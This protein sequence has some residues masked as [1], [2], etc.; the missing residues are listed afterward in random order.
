MSLQEGAEY[1]ERLMSIFRGDCPPNR[2]VTVE[3]MTHD[4]W[5]SMRT[6]DQEMAMEILEPLFQFMRAQ[7]DSVRMK[8]MGLGA[9]LQYREKDVGRA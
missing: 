4:L 3:W 6:H 1:N 9:Y 2:S 7:T 8:P 5:E